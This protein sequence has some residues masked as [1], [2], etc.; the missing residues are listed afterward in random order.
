[1]KQKKNILCILLFIISSMVPAYADEQ[2]SWLQSTVQFCTQ[3]S[4]IIGVLVVASI[5]TANK[6]RANCIITTGKNSYFD[7]VFTGDFGDDFTFA[8]AKKEY[9]Y[10][11]VSHEEH[12]FA[13]AEDQSIT[14]VNTIGSITVVEHAG[15]NIIIEITKQAY[16]D[17]VFDGIAIDC[18]QTKD[19]IIV[20]AEQPQPLAAVVTE[21]TTKLPLFNKFFTRNVLIQTARVDYLILIPDRAITLDLSTVVGD[22]GVYAGRGVVRAYSKYGNCYVPE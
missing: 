11:V 4:V 16:C 12:T 6:N 14:I 7:G 3:P 1:M 18:N 8:C 13:V 5:Y 15:D 22:V 19:G 9:A 21:S 20:H 17:T 2:H 10:P